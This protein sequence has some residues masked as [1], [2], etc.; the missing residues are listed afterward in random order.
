M[1]GAQHPG[2]GARAECGRALQPVAFEIKLQEPAHI[3]NSDAFAHA[4]GLTF[5]A[6]EI[7]GDLP[8]VIVC[9]RGSILPVPLEE[10]GLFDQSIHR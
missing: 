4:S 1:R 7:G 10:G 6:S 3:G 2:Q 5:G 9:E 8:A